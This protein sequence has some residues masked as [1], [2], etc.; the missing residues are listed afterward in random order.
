LRSNIKGY[1]GKT[2]YTDSQTSNTT[3]PSGRDLYHFQ[4]LLQVASPE[5]SGYTLVQSKSTYHLCQRAWR[6]LHDWGHQD[7]KTWEI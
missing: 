4:F 5:T 1:G 2:H 3:A 7:D 6:S